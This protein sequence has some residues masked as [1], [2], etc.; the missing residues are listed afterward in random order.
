MGYR[1]VELTVNTV[2]TTPAG[3]EVAEHR[4]GR[5]VSWY[6]KNISSGGAAA[7]IIKVFCIDTITSLTTQ[8]GGYNLDP[9]ELTVDSNSEAYL[10]WQGRIIAVSDTDGATLAIAE[11]VK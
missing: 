1:N 8:T 6:V 5:R 9:K 3:T 2:A 11:R 7:A 4:L 10:C